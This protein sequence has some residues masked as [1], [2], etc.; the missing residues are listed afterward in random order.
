MKYL[1]NFKKVGVC[2]EAAYKGDQHPNVLGAPVSNLPLLLTKDFLIV[3]G[4]SR[5]IAVPIAW[6]LLHSWLQQYYYRI[7]IGQAS[8]C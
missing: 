4:L 1:S 8:L 6:F 3:V 5:V 7:S 2:T